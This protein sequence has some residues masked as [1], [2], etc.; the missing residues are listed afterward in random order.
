M[1]ADTPIVN[2]SKETLDQITPALHS[3]RDSLR[4]Q[5]RLLTDTFNLQKEARD[6]AEM[7]ANLAQSQVKANDVADEVAKGAKDAGG[8]SNS[9]SFLGLVGIGGLLGGLSTGL[10]VS[11][12]S[13]VGVLT[14]QLKAIEYYADLFTPEKLQKN[15]KGMRLG[16]AMNMDLFKSSFDERLANIRTSISTTFDNFK[17]N[18]SDSLSRGITKL[19]SYFIFDETSDVSKIMNSFK[20]SVTKLLAPF[21]LAVTTLTDLLPST[22]ILSDTITSLK[23][24]ASNVGTKFTALL[25]PL[26][27]FG[28]KVGAIGR[29]VGKVFAPIAIIT[30]AW[31]TIT[32]TIEGYKEGGI[33]GGLQGAIDG[34]FTSLVTIP[35]DMVKNAA[36]WVLEKV[37]LISPET[38]ESVKSFSF[39]EMFDGMTDKVF[40]ALTSAVEW[41]KD[42]FSFDP[43]R[44]PSIDD[45]LNKTLLAPY[46][47]LK[48]GVGHLLNLFGFDKE[49]EVVKN[50]DIGKL[51]VDTVTSVKDFVIDTFNHVVDSIKAFDPMEALGDLSNIG[52]DFI[53]NILRGVLPPPDLM[54]FSAPE[55]SIF[56][57]KFGGQ[58]VNLNPIPASVYE[59]AGINSATGER[60]I[61]SSGALALNRSAAT[62]QDA[63]N[64][65]ARQ[66]A[67]I[68][69]SV[70]V[71][72]TTVVNKGGDSRTITLQANPKIS[73]QLS[74]AGG[75]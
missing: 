7:R 34:F 64:S 45:I 19:K 28:S 37:G 31:D 26:K 55:V 30:T 60:I 53:A 25:E 67:A 50:F 36:A 56:G 63:A 12:G 18:F 5:T 4:N 74:F 71:G 11:I 23:T 68:A 21:T 6:Q 54:T 44:M 42:L 61:T 40:G 73:S 72:P 62:D 32:G 8:G 59:F 10:A 75:F 15:F 57:K 17:T 38:S 49:S 22:T 35:L 58:T 3:M 14:G 24:S 20:A 9:S 65:A 47:I 27:S 51:I 16:I 33:I 43:E 41:V 66:A 1:A 69:A 52:K 46:N 13:L 48:A 70:N 2:L 29:T 39:T